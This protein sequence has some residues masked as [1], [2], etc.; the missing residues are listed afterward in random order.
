MKPGSLGCFLYSDAFE[1]EELA[2]HA[3]RAEAAGYE[4][5]WYVEALHYETFACGAFLLSQTSTIE[6]G[7]GISNI[8]ARDPMASVQG[9]RSLHEFSGGRFILGLGVSHDVLVREIRG[10]AYERPYTFMC[11]YLD[12]MDAARPAVP[13]EDPPVV[14]A[15][16]GPRM[17]ELGGARTQGILPANCPPEH[18]ER[19]RKALGPDPWIITLQHAVLCEDPVKARGIARNAIQF[20]AEAPNYFNNWYRYGFD[21]TDLKDGGSDRLVDALVAWGSL[22]QIQAKIQQHF[23][24]GAT[25]VAVNAIAYGEGG[26]PL[27]ARVKGHELGYACL[28]DWDLHE[29]LTKGR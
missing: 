26:E 15:A 16:L 10:H 3:K 25:Q 19:A 4:T 23:D 24:A 27:T 12:G 21:E 13:G 29:A 18:T 8:Y 5:L 20:Y 14:L 9:A 1:R 2:A 17:V 28:P 11:D 22:D 7:S 6:V